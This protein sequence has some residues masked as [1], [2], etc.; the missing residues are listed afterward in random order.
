MTDL[1]S[2]LAILLIIFIV[3]NVRYVFKLRAAKEKL[4]REIA[5]HALAS[6][7]YKQAQ[8]TEIAD[9]RATVRHLMQRVANLESEKAC[10]I[11][12]ARWN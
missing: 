11:A 4:T 2:A 12:A 7:S 3:V 6:Q 10:K 5:G 8:E 1:N 9:A